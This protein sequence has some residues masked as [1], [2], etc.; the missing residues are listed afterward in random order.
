MHATCS[1]HLIDQTLM[2]GHDP[3]EHIKAHATGRLGSCA[4]NGAGG[5]VNTN[6][7]KQAA[8]K[9]LIGVVILTHE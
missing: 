6:Q 9:G 4:G 2:T 5:I 1:G 3:D 8:A 7:L